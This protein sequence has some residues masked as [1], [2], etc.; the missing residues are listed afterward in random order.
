[1]NISEKKWQVKEKSMINRGLRNNLN[2]ET[3]RLRDP[4]LQLVVKVLLKA[5][6][7]VSLR[8]DKK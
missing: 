7:G 6:L 8:L 3:M 1:M 5:L 2:M 4:C